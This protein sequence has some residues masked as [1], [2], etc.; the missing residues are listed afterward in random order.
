[1]SKIDEGIA[2]PT[3]SQP[4]IEQLQHYGEVQ[5]TKVG[6]ILFQVG[7]KDY[8]WFVII[9]GALEILSN[10][11]TN[12]D[13]LAVRT[14]GQFLGEISL[15]TGQT[16]FLTA[17][18]QQAGSVLKISS[19]KLR[20]II[21]TNPQ[22]SELVLNA[23]LMRREI[24]RGNAATSALKIVGSRF[25]SDTQR[26]RAFA[27]RNQLPHQWIDVEQDTQAEVLLTAFH[28][29]P[30]DTPIVIW[31]GK[32]VLRNP[33][34]SDLTRRLGLN[35]TV[36]SGEMVDLIVI[37]A[38]PGGLA[39]S[40]YGASEGLSTLTLEA[41]STG[42][43]AGTSSK[44]ENYLGFP[45]GLSG[46]ELANRAVAQA[47]KFGARIVVSQAATQL[48]EEAGHYVVQLADGE[49]V[50]AQNVII[51]TGARYRKLPIAN[52]P[53]YEG[54]GVYYAATQTEAQLC[55]NEPIMVVGGGNSAGQAAIFLAGHA[56]KVYI[57]IRRESL[58]S[59]MSRYLIDR[60]ER[61]DNI[62]VLSHT[63]VVGLGGERFLEQVVIQNNQTQEQQELPIKALF[64]FI[65]ADPHTQWL[66]DVV[67]LDDQGFILTGNAL[68]QAKGWNITTRAPF[69]LETS[70]P[71][72]FAVGDVRSGSVK[73]V[74]SAVGEGSIAVKFIFEYL[75]AQ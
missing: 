23:F 57:V 28:V 4:Q 55:Y 71:G 51:A 20:E 64:T 17:R 25:S 19:E 2:Y 52:L 41:V 24:L 27:A 50:A 63:E 3:L 7:D 68:E 5:T 47:Q 32:E 9:E 45:A 56:Q 62:T 40:V 22:I 34:D 72:V 18:V 61:T 49:E 15:L 33:T 36:A 46:A 6:D 43:Q 8:D 73:R 42:G 38:G 10:A 35:R 21:A 59:S 1:M 48:R 67:A 66:Q 31:Q 70:L 44:I 26:L 53:K 39:A 12:P 74:A 75:A 65:G 60:I 16:A 30:Q 14:D 11:D 69:L 13:I 58:V 37:G 54:Q 29:A